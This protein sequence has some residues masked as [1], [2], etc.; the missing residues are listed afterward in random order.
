MR[1]EWTGRYNGHEWSIFRGVAL[2]DYQVTIGVVGR[3][4]VHCSSY[5]EALNA[6]VRHII[7]ATNA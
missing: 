7:G 1:N 5:S 6:I 2:L 3:Y 4:S